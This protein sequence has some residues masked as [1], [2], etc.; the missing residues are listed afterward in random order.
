MTRREFAWLA[1]G[2]GLGMAMP[3]RGRA[4]GW[5]GYR[6]AV[7]VDGC[8]GPG[9]PA[10][11]DPA[12]PLTPQAVSDAAA[13]GV[14]AV[15]LTVG[16][17]GEALESTVKNLAGAEREIDLH[18]DVF[19]KVKRAADLRAAKASGRV[20]LVYGTQDL[21]MIGTDLGRLE[22]LQRL[23]V[24][25]VQPTYNGRNLLGDGCLE[26]GNA[27]L[28][29]LGHAALGRIHEL[30][31]VL[32]L[33]HCGQRTT[34]EA[35]AASARPVAI[36]HTGCA[37][38]HD[39][40]RNKRDAELRACAERGG[41]V[42]IY[43]M[44]YLRGRGQPTAADVVRHVEHTWKVCGEDH[45][46]I[47]TDG[48][49]SAFVL[50]ERFKAAHRAMVRKR[51]EAGIGAPGEDEEVYN[52]VPELNTPRRLETLAALLLE[53]GHPEPKVAKLVG[54]NFARLFSEVMG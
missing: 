48:P 4:A 36:T 39:H 32:D 17:P 53:R 42:G 8:G 5:S 1:A 33:S 49:L 30:R 16:L 45:V 23:G 46:G 51:R 20:G 54:G 14:T 43:F 22:V 41:V 24:R 15:N 27:G 7:V 25:I 34:A 21:A 47:G 13:S 11:D 6:D 9:D 50:T 19:L 40:P 44:A 31:M 3:G 38:L 10:E 35:I 18:P 28:S 12:A 29:T 2:A 26:P 37:A 52:F